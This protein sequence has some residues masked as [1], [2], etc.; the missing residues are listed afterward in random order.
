MTTRHE[1]QGNS[2]GVPVGGF[3]A[4]GGIAKVQRH[5]PPQHG[6]HACVPH[7]GRRRGPAL[8]HK[9]LWRIVKNSFNMVSVDGDNSSTNETW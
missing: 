7:H 2:R 5:D 8:L 1:A 4:A 3:P 9:A 6:H